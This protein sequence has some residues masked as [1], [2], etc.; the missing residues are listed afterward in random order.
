METENEKINKIEWKALEYER[1]EHSI[2][3][4]WTIGIITVVSS[5]SAIWMH[6]YMFGVFI[7]I[8][9]FCLIL[10]ST[11]EPRELS[12]S[13]SNKGLTVENN[14]YLWKSLKGFDMKKGEGKVKF[15]IEVDKYFLPKYTFFV[16]NE[17]ADEV[18]NSMMKFIPKIEIEESKSIMFME[19]LGF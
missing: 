1:K 10:L 19:K 18:K 8:S 2:D 3:W 9:G 14:I 13:L 5:V 4:F 17:L 12:Y 11:Q 15:L 7:L 6:N 16:P